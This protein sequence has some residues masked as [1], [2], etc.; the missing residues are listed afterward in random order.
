[1]NAPT[2]PAGATTTT[3]STTTTTATSTTSGSSGSSGPTGAT[4]CGTDTN[5]YDTDAW[6]VAFAPAGAP[7]IAV[8]VVLPDQ[9]AA[10][11]SQGGTVAAPIA[12]S[13]IQAYLAYLA[14][15]PATK[16]AAAGST[17]TTLAQHP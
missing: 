8:A 12:K 3:T 17:S 6:F 1:M 14:A 16:P 10:N 13:V 15:P 9:P 7:T 5:P 4:G 11:E 2:G